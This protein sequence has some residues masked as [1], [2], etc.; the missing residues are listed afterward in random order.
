MPIGVIGLGRC[1]I[2]RYTE[3]Q[4]ELV[5]TFADQAVIAI[6]SVETFK[7]L[8]ERTAELTRSVSELE[9]LE[10]VLRAVNSSLDLDTVLTTIVSRAVQLSRA[11]EGTIYEYDV[12]EQVFVPKSAFGMSAERVAA[13]RERRIKLGETHLGRSAI[14]RAPVY[15]EDVQQDPSW[16]GN[17]HHQSMIQ[18]WTKLEFAWGLA[19]CMAEA[20]GATDPVTQQMLGEICSYAELTKAAVHY[21]EDG[22]YEYGNGAWFLDH[23]PLD[24]LRA[25]L[26]FWFPRVNEIIRLIGSHNVLC[27]PTSAQFAD[28]TLRPLIDKYL[29][30]AGDTTAEDRARIF[31]LGWDFAGTAL[32]SRNEQYERF[33]A[34]SGARNRQAVQFWANRTEANRLVDRFLKEAH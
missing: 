33:Y 18:A 6:G 12:S 3:R 24:A 13:L 9:A 32:A 4:I 2:E 11:D 29:R 23:K 7:A 19:T 1:R 20:I 28:P 14:L 25:T 27:T 17:A 26:P 34:A 10:G 21:G 8:Q 16:R 30:G 31:R 15:V 5:R 22:A